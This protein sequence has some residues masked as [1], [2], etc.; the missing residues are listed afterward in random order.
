ME[1]RK[2]VQMNLLARKEQRCRYRVQTSGCWG[3]SG[4]W[5]KLRE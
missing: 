1:S 2:T 5:D 3:G 4:G